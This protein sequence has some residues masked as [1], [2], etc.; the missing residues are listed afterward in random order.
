MGGNE[1]SGRLSSIIKPKRLDY[2]P[3]PENLTSD[4]VAGTLAQH[5]SKGWIRNEA[6]E[7]AFAAGYRYNEAL[8]AH[9]VEFFPKFLRHSQ[10]QWAG[11]VFELAD[12]HRVNIIEPLFGWV[13]PNGTR[14][15]RST[16]FEEPKKQGKS[17]IAAG[18]GLY[19]LVADGE[20]GA[21][22]YSFGADAKQA[23]VVHDEAISMV[24][25]SPALDHILTINRTNGN[26]R[27]RATKSWYKRASGKIRGNHGLKIHCGILDELHEW[28][29]RALWGQVKYAGRSRRQPIRFVITNAG[30]DIGSVCYEQRTKALRHES[31][32][33]IDHTFL[34]HVLRVPEEEALAEMDAVADGATTLPVARKCNPMLGVIIEEE[35]LVQ[36]IRDA[37]ESPAE[38]ENLLRLTYGIWAA[39][40]ETPLLEP[41]SWAK[42]QGDVDPTELM[43]QPCGSAL[44]LADVHDPVSFSIAWPSVE[45]EGEHR[46]T[47]LTWTWLARK[48]A[49]AKRNKARDLFA[50][51]E[52]EPLARLKL[53]P[54]DV[55]DYSVVR[56][57]IIALCERFGVKSL[58]FDPRQAEK[59]T[60]EICDGIQDAGGQ[61]VLKGV[62]GLERRA[63]AQHVGNYGEP[64][65]EFER[66]VQQ[67]RIEHD[68]NPLLAWEA[69]HC[70]FETDKD[71]NKKPI[72]PG[73]KLDHRKV[74]GIQTTVMAIASCLHYVDLSSAY[75]NEGSGVVLF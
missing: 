46:Y 18:V 35:E 1:R 17:A 45:G 72:K 40:S 74:D 54:G 10:G 7:R 12:H 5:R 9:V 60:Q 44:D 29:G 49:L 39:G 67:R 27:Y 65:R 19:C 62:D 56:N 38:K 36:D 32:E 75:A 37:I 42:C 23:S 21:H 52:H 43:G 73:S 51:W 41:G 4:I 61:T 71:G 22:C 70:S 6:D 16:Y 2:R 47:T 33:V 48:N 58:L 63:F 68:G 64:T 50:K 30:D 59:M 66:A 34:C 11:M 24:E 69:S 55:T 53:T 20:E 13:R 26:I 8:A 3:K 28:H 31:G 57:D 14:R 25:R 15:F